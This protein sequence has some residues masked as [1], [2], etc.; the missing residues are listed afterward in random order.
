MLKKIDKFITYNIICVLIFLK[1]KTDYAISS[2]Y[3]DVT[4]C[5]LFDTH[6][7]LHCFADIDS[8]GGKKSLY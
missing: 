5:V 2:K 4:K 8:A 3:V 7:I 1:N 6:F